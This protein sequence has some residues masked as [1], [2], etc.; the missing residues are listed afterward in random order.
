MTT[1]NS[2]LPTT[3][4]NEDPLELQTTDCCVVGGGPAGVMLAFLLARQGINV[5]LLEKHKDFNRDFRG[6]TI[7][8]STMQVLDQLGL[9]NRL[10]QLRHSKVHALNARISAGSTTIA[11]LSR[12]K[13]RFPYITMLPQEQF[14]DFMVAE[15]QQYPQFKLVMSA[16]VQAVIEEAGQVVGVRY[17]GHGG[18][19]EIRAKLIVAADGRASHL[20]EWAGFIPKQT[21]APMDVLWFR[22]PRSPADDGNIE[23]RIA[24]GKMLVVID[25]FDYWQFG[26]VIP[27]GSYQDLRH[28]GLPALRQSILELVPEFGDRLNALTEWSQIAFLS[29]ESSCLP[30]WYRP[31]LLLI[32]DAAHVMSPVAGVGINYAIQD[33]VVATNILSQPLKAGQVELKHLATVQNRRMLPTKVIQTFQSIV[34]G[35]I[36]SP[37]LSSAPSFKV[38]FFL[39]LPVLRVWVAR[40]IA[41][42]VWPVHLKIK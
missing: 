24:G 30:R 1:N 34:Q 6:D 31:G 35:R 27:K 4:T 9:A 26:F 21:S 16:N 20:R 15:A 38:P 28:Q 5:T 12:L 2:N 7:H 41:F 19:H 14:L 39:R 17:R 33:A 13:T 10:L 36:I 11:D 22:L 25:R 40:L 23:M 18:Q 37:A 42:G 29:V 3:Q 32:G 8:P